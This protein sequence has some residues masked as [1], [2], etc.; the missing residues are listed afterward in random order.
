MISAI[1]P[2]QI[3]RGAVEAFAAE[4][5][6]VVV[7]ELHVTDIGENVFDLKGQR[8]RVD[9]AAGVVSDLLDGVDLIGAKFPARYGGAPSAVAL[10]LCVGRRDRH[11]GW[12]FEDSELD[13]SSELLVEMSGAGKCDRFIGLRVC[14]RRL[15]RAYPY[16][17]GL[18]GQR[19]HSQIGMRADN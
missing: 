4:G 17:E 12:T 18:A 7:G 10:Y 14:D 2:V 13:F 9:P 11:W 15:A 6:L 5:R 19:C 1:G 8:Q 3:H 16:A